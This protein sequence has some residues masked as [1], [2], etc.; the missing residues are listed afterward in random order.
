MIGDTRQVRKFL[1]LPRWLPAYSVGGPRLF[2][3]L[4]YAT[5]QQKR[6][7]LTSYMPE[8]CGTTKYPKWI[9]LYWID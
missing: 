6:V 9:N 2:R 1:L 3:W 8:A 7:S 4:E 5:I